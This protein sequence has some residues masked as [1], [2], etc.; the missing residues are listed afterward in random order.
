MLEGRERWRQQQRYKKNKKDTGE[1]R[2]G[3]KKTRKR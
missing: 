3:I 1:S 2:S